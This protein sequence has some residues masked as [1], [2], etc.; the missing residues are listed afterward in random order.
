MTTTPA[1]VPV[2]HAV[3]AAADVVEGG[4]LVVDIGSVTV[5][6]F[7]FRR[8]LYAYDN[9]CAHQGGPVCQGRIVHR[10][11]EV[12]DDGKRSRGM[13]FDEDELHVVCPWHGAEY[14]VVTGAHPTQP[15]FRLR[16]YPVVEEEGT[17]YV[18]V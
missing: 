18:T 4:R 6:I 1:D 14:S 12:L 16:R 15:A 10:V 17:V 13:R 8:Q 11:I 3:A 5:G 7:R 2:R 9:T